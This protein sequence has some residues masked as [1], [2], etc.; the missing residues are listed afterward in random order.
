VLKMCRD[1]GRRLPQKTTEHP[2][3][4]ET[5]TRLINPGFRSLS[6]WSTIWLASVVC[7]GSS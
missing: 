6:N 7:L 1:F 5:V 3:H 2:Y 4:L